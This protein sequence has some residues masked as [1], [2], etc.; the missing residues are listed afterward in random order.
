MRVDRCE[1]VA[2][3]GR[4]SDPDYRR[5]A[6]ANHADLV[7]TLF[8]IS[9][10]TA[11]SMKPRSPARSPADRTD[12]DIDTLANRIAHIRTWTFAA[13][14]PRWLADPVHWQERTRAIEDRL[15]DA[16]HERL[17]QRFVDRRTSVLMRRLRENTMLDAEVTAT[18]DVLVE[19]QHVGQLQGFR[20]APD[21]G[22]VGPDGKALRAA[23]Q[24]SLAGEIEHRA[25]R[26]AA[27]PNADLIL[28]ADGIV[29]WRGDTVARLTETGDL[30]KPR[31]LLLADEIL[32][33]PPRDKVQDRLDLWLADHCAAL[34]KPLFDLQASADLAPA[35]RGVAFRLVENLGVIER[36]EIADDV[37]ALDQTMRA[38]LRRLGVRFGA[39]HIY[40][41]LLLK[42]GPSQL[43]AVLWA[44]RNGGRE[45]PGVAELPQL[46]ASGRTT[47][48]IDPAFPR[49]L[50][51]TVGFRI[52]GP[53]AIRIDIL[54][55]LADLIPAIGWRPTPEN[56]AMLTARLRAAASPSRW[57]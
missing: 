9:P 44:L 40:V 45:T 39:W 16:L 23:A 27:A 21:P 17:T 11:P 49:A 10:A 25:E 6:P 7:M 32:T 36:A 8:G 30:L 51:R 1:R 57:R 24:K 56:T 48:P 20:F 19:G 29:R 46:S 42:P 41:P 28:S 55:R 26:L 35:A 54:E 47:I 31:L 37:R 12:G 52:A 5:I 14:R 38:G 53:R 22:A 15:S 13:N 18:G 50:Y 33:G 2:A 43:L 34:L 4:L 3:M